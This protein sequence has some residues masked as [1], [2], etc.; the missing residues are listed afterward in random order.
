MFNPF[1]SRFHNIL[2]GL[3]CKV[4]EL[5]YLFNWYIHLVELFVCES[6]TLTVLCVPIA[7]SYLHAEN[8]ISMP[9][10]GCIKIF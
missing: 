2:F 5:W 1:F 8:R 10:S 9:G 7:A 3:Q 4:W 6:G